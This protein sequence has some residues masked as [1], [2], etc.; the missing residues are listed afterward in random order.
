MSPGRPGR[1]IF[2]SIFHI[3]ILHRF[4]MDFYGFWFPFRFHFLIFF[5]FSAYLFRASNLHGFF[6]DF[7][8]I[9]GTPDHVKKRFKRYTLHKNQEITGSENSSISH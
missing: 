9:S 3:K 4:G 2:S 5:M 1:I 6:M 7:R 8:R